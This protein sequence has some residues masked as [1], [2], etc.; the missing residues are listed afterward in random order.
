MTR[1]RPQHKILRWTPDSQGAPGEF[2]AQGWSGRSDAGS[3][4]SRVR[5]GQLHPEAG[6]DLARPV[7]SLPTPPMLLLF[8]RWKPSS[9]S[10][11]VDVDRK[12]VGGTGTRSRP[13]PRMPTPLD[14]SSPPFERRE[15]SNRGDRERDRHSVAYRR[16]GRGPLAGAEGAGLSAGARGQAAGRQARPLSP[17]ATGRGRGVRGVGRRGSGWL[18]R[19]RSRRRAVCGR[20]VT[21]GVTVGP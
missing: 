6:G 20:R 21:N 5:E 11:V 1:I 19:C 10:R 13:I 9:S 8:G 7:H 4:F 14:R 3:A 16:A 15:L 18:S 17:L 2:R 12:K